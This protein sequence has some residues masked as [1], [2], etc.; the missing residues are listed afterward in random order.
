V[1]ADLHHPC[2]GYEYKATINDA[3]TENYGLNAVRDGANIP[4]TSTGA[5]IKFFYDN[6]SHWVTDNVNSLIVTAPGSF[7]SELGCPAGDW[8]PTACGRGSRTSTGRDLHLHTTAIPAGSY[9]SKVT[10]G[11]AGRRTMDR[12][13]SSTGPTF[14]SRFLPTEAR[15]LPVQLLH[16]PP[17]HRLQWRWR[18][19]HDRD[20]CGKPPERAGLPRRLDA[21]VRHHHLTYDASDDVWQGTF[22]IPFG[23]AEY[24]APLN[25][26][27][28]ENY[29]LNATRDGANIPIPAP[30]RP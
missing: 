14:P 17:V 1:A 15:A 10:I 12:A 28:T 3:W 19:P 23:N 11:R 2:G 5:P 20:D 7:Q 26:S 29:G 24:K 25:D 27:W 22:T 21:G 18:R 8:Q 4:L 9:E 6:K 16:P 13:A 30:A